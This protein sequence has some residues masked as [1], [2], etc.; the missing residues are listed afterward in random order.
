MAQRWWHPADLKWSSPSLSSHPKSDAPLYFPTKPTQRNHFRL[1]SLPYSLYFLNLQVLWIY[2]LSFSSA[3][4][5]LSLDSSPGLHSHFIQPSLYIDS[6]HHSYVL[7]WLCLYCSDFNSFSSPKPRLTLLGSVLEIPIIWPL[8]IC[9]VLCLSSSLEFTQA[10]A[11]PGM[12]S[13]ISALL[14][15]CSCFLRRLPHYD[16]PSDSQTNATVTLSHSPRQTQ[17]PIVL[18]PSPPPHPPAELWVDLALVLQLLSF[19]CELPVFL[20]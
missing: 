20:Y 6:H 12:L 11:W 10:F 7:I 2:I 9:P 1:L 19:F 8:P 15:H 18:C 13:C 17:M 16:L 5:L 14:M 3:T 4:A